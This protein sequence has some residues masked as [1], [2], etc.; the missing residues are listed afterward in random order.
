MKKSAFNDQGFDTTPDVSIAKKNLEFWDTRQI[1][2]FEIRSALSKELTNVVTDQLSITAD[3]LNS[4]Y[5]QIFSS[6]SSQHLTNYKYFDTILTFDKLDFCKEISKNAQLYQEFTKSIA[7]ED[8]DCEKNSLGKVAYIKNPYT[9]KAYLSFSKI[10]TF[11]RYSYFSSF[12][13]VCEEVYSG[14][15]EYCILPIENATDGKLMSFYS[16]I[17]KYELKVCAVCQVVHLDSQSFTKF[18]LLKKSISLMG[19]FNTGESYLNRSRLEIRISQTS[20]NDSSLHNILYAANVCSLKL[21]RIDSLPL[22]YNTKLFGHYVI[23]SLNQADLKTFLMY[24]ALEFPQSYVV[25]IYSP[26]N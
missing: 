1:K 11:P 4:L 23:F 5:N 24:L 18:A 21:Q 8:E 6:R 20:E 12:Q 17:D 9:D 3:S 13:A 16:M 19:I 14:S 26:V 10:I 7:G 25:G 22:S 2:F 15:C